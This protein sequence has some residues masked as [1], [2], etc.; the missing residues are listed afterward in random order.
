MVYVSPSLL[1][2]DFSVIK[3]E[4][5]SVKNADYLHVD[6]MDGMF[7]SQKTLF[8]D[9]ENVKLVHKYSKIPIHTHLMVEHPLSLIKSYAKEGSSI[10]SFHVEAKDDPYAVIAAI[11]K[12]KCKVSIALNPETAV[13]K[14]LPY[15]ALVDHVL[16]MS[17]VPGKGGQE[18]IASSTAKIRLLKQ[19]ILQMDFQILIEVDGGIKLENC[20]QPIIAGADVLISGTGI[21][22]QKDK[23][24]RMEAVEKMKEVI[25]LG[26]D[27]AGYQLKE[28]VKQ[29]LTQKGIAYKDFG[30][31]SEESVDYPLYAQKVAKPISQGKAKRGILVCGTG[32]GMAIAANRYKGVRASLCLDT[33]YAQQAREHGDSNVLCLAGRVTQQKDIA[34]IL[35]AWLDTP[36]SNE[37][38]RIR[39]LQEIDRF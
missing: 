31:N 7:V 6:V 15:L 5:S 30:T 18:Y 12:Q 36:F 1:A 9:P 37:D 23:D 32:Q 16:I 29:L 26:A 28:Y 22:G 8:F 2:A 20:F 33:F 17:V 13:E 21:F 3:E 34:A 11:K 24:K 38:K 4:L 19:I 25:L 35:D 39:R 27:H 10:I 14:I